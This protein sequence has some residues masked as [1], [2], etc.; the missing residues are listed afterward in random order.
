[1]RSSISVLICVRNAE[2]H[3]GTCIRS[4]L[5]QTYSDFEIVVI[6]DMSS[7]KTK[8]I[9]EKF[10]DKRIKYFKN[11]KWLGISKSRNKAVSFAEGEYVFFTDGDCQVS[12]N[13]VEKGMKLFEDPDC[14]GVEGK[15]YYV[16]E[17]PCAF[18]SNRNNKNWTHSWLEALLGCYWFNK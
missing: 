15:I 17:E 5:E 6:D 16:S 4:I 11:E 13:W 14:V 1:M 8:C 18:V 9:I 10:D 3:I 2:N 7:D 12:K